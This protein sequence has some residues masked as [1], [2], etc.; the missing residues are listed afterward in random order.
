MNPSR[1]FECMGDGSLVIRMQLSVQL[2]SA[3]TATAADVSV[4]SKKS[5]NVWKSCPEMI[6]L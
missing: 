3:T 1:S 6:S 5:P 2:H 4:T